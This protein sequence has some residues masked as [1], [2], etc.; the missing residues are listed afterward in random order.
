MQQDLMF[1]AVEFATRAHS[2]QYRK[3]TRVPYVLHPLRV[4]QILIE[5]ESTDAV[6]VAGILHDTVEDTAVTLADI[7]EAFGGEVSRLVES[8]SE[9]DKRAPWEERKQHT[10]ATLRSAGHDTLLIACADK[11][12]NLRSMHRGERRAGPA[13]WDRFHRPR[14]QQA[15]YYREVAAAIRAGDRRERLGHLGSA[16]QRKVETLF[17]PEHNAND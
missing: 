5:A 17:G 7:R 16:L 4:A 8:V 9:P 14:E 3:G 10:I 2:G 13:F 12:D 6:V 15:W 1:K 11:L